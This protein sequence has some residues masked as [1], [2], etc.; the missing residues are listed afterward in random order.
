MKQVILNVSLISNS[1]LIHFHKMTIQKMGNKEHITIKGINRNCK[2]QKFLLTKY[3]GK[4]T[5]TLCIT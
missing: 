3:Y 2:S 4:V 5:I 1:N